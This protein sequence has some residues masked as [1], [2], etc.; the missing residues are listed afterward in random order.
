MI[1]LR[2]A[3]IGANALFI[4]YGVL[5]GIYPTILVNC[6]LMPLNFIRLQ[7]MRRLISRVKDAG[8]GDLS[9]DW[10]RSFVTRRTFRA[11][12]YLWRIGDPASEAIYIFSGEVELAEIETIVQAGELIGEM[13][14]FH[15]DQKRLLSARCMT[16]V[17]AGILTYDEFRLLYFQN[18]EFG[19]YL[20][21][22]VTRRMQD[23][24]RKVAL[25]N[26]RVSFQ[27]EAHLNRRPG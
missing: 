23:S 22:L 26:G 15:K 18:P 19:F 2:V 27:R 4:A 8:A 13:G 11:G 5:K 17:T 1:P 9:S 7:D 21:G 20:L 25:P 24:F 6:I 10:I 12:D 3:S 14:L 16:D